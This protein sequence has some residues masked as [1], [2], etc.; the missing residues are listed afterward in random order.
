M[1]YPN[2]QPIYTIGI[3]ARL[4]G[5]C[6]ATLRLWEKKGLIQPYRIGKNRFYS[7]CNMERLRKIKRLL[8]KERI[9]IAGVKK[10][11]DGVLCWQIKNCSPEEKENCPAYLHT[12]PFKNHL[13]YTQ[14]LY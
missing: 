11:L 5:V 1:A 4:L 6:Q 10:V 8:Q 7:E 9:N 14:R 3:T 12:N 13:N 2:N